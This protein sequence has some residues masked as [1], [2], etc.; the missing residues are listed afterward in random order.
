MLRDPAQ[1]TRESE[2]DS[3]LVRRRP[4][5]GD[6]VPDRVHQRIGLGAPKEVNALEGIAQTLEHPL[7][8]GERRDLLCGDNCCPLRVQP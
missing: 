4:G 3:D 6:Q 8:I 5:A 7:L 1:L 2:E